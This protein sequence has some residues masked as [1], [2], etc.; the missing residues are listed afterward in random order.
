[1]NKAKKKNM[2]TVYILRGKYSKKENR[3]NMFLIQIQITVKYEHNKFCKRMQWLKRQMVVPQQKQID[4]QSVKENN[5]YSTEN[6]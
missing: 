4:T 5:E 3:E 1:M 6:I 2:Y